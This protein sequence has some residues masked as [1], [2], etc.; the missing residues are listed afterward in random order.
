MA[1]TPEAGPRETESTPVDQ[2]PIAK[3]PTRKPGKGSRRAAKKHETA[4]P[5][6]RRER[7]YPSVGL[8]EVLKIGE[9]II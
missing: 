8:S 3:H 2:K 7:P 6:S 1:E 4:E 9:A 5:R